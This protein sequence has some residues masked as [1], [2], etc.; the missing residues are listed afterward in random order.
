[1]PVDFR[2]TAIYPEDLEEWYRRVRQITDSVS[3]HSMAKYGDDEHDALE[4]EYDRQSFKVEESLDKEGLEH[5]K[6]QVW[7][8]RVSPTQTRPADVGNPACRRRCC[9]RE[10]EA[11][12]NNQQMLI[13]ILGVLLPVILLL[14]LLSA[15]AVM[16]LNCFGVPKH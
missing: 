9:A 7:F 16:K 1:M 12:K 5:L 6:G 4:F 2:I 8:T 10:D 11:T 14:L 3:Q 15:P 13:V